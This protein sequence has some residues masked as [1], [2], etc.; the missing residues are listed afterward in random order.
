MA[1][2]N[3]YFSKGTSSL[4][5]TWASDPILSGADWIIGDK[6]GNDERALAWYDSENTVRVHNYNGSTWDTIFERVSQISGYCNDADLSGNFLTVG[7]PTFRNNTGKIESWYLDAEISANTASTPYSGWHMVT[8]TNIETY[9]G[10]GNNGLGDN[11]SILGNDILIASTS[12]IVGVNTITYDIYEYEMIYKGNLQPYRFVSTEKVKMVETNH[13][14]KVLEYGDNRRYNIYDPVKGVNI[15]LIYASIDF[16]QNNASGN[17]IINSSIESDAK[18]QA[19]DGHINQVVQYGNVALALKDETT[20]NIKYYSFVDNEYQEL[21]NTAVLYNEPDTLSGVPVFDQDYFN[22]LS[23]PMAKLSGIE[24]AY[25]GEM[26]INTTFYDFD[27]GTLYIDMFNLHNE[28][29][30]KYDTDA[31]TEESLTVPDSTNVVLN[32]SREY[33]RM[34]LNENNIWVSY[35]VGTN[36]LGTLTGVTYPLDDS[37]EETAYMSKTTATT[38][39]AFDYPYIERIRGVYRLT[40]N[41]HKS[42]IY[43]IEILN[44]NLNENITDLTTRSYI[45][46][47]VE[48]AILQFQEKVAPVHTQLWKIIWKGL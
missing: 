46:S 43:S 17:P 5:S 39:T 21:P 8:Y 25:F 38:G 36:Y 19:P 18:M 4:S 2:I 29:D 47:I 27:Y 37:A 30:Y 48:R 9:D 7:I 28:L 14:V 15:G 22:A 42:N 26:P 34:D 10:I 6:A 11:V 45:Q 13:N 33:E 16:A 23:A 40:T 20:E 24:Y 3:D 31:Y 41:A 12:G 1:D 32:N 35:R 44:S